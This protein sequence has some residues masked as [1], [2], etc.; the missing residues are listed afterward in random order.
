MQSNPGRRSP[1][2]HLREVLAW[3]DTRTLALIFLI[4]QGL[5]VVTTQRALATRRFQEGNPWLDEVT[6]HHPLLVYGAKLGIA[7]LV[8]GALLLLRLR[9]RL[10]LAVLVVFTA[11]SLVAPV[12]NLMRVT[13]AL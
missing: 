12:A 9:W 7:L 10:R 5:D 13:G 8:L 4:T 1:I 11:A 6:N 3:R 2:D